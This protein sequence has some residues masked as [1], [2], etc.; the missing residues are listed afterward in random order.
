MLNIYW[1]NY[2]QS[3]N[4]Q[5][6]DDKH[7]LAGEMHCKLEKSHITLMTKPGGSLLTYCLYQVVL[8][9]APLPTST[10]QGVPSSV[11]QAGPLLPA[12]S[13]Q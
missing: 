10:E 11:G 1:Y 7:V 8:L 9:I 2:M 12:V 3:E 5:A 13:P 4:R 6:T